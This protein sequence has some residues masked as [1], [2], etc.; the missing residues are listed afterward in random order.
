M[1]GVTETEDLEAQ[2]E[3]LQ[4]ATVDAAAATAAFA[5]AAA[6]LVD[7]SDLADIDLHGS[8]DDPASDADTLRSTS[9]DVDAAIHM[10]VGGS[11]NDATHGSEAEDDFGYELIA[12]GE[13][14]SSDSFD[15]FHDS[16]HVGEEADV[17]AESVIPGMMGTSSGA[18]ETAGG[19]GTSVSQEPEQGM[20]ASTPPTEEKLEL[21]QVTT[22]AAG[23]QED[24]AQSQHS[25]P[26][27]AESYVGAGEPIDRA[28][29]DSNT[30]ASALRGSATD[31]EPR[32]NGEGSED[33]PV[34][35]HAKG[36]QGSNVRADGDSAEGG[37]ANVPGVNLERLYVQFFARVTCGW[38]GSCM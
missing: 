3:A 24:Q 15:S 17:G 10:H 35:K 2:L 8:L 1:F 6:D 29:T 26:E 9:F 11:G 18:A 14:V 34:Q 31:G 33:L 28:S 12:T 20:H 13:G 7:L 30:G 16:V 4:D 19:S 5:A 22:G 21:Q 23:G 38:V 36:S 25:T 37:S 32:W 27:P